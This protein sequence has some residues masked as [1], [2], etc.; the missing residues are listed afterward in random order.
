M[1]SLMRCSVEPL[2]GGRPSR[3]LNWETMMMI[4]T[5]ARKPVMIGSDRSSAIQ[6]KRRIPTRATRTPTSTAT[7]PT[8]AT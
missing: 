6:P 5:P 7:N 3:S 4:A 2:V 1:T 8:K